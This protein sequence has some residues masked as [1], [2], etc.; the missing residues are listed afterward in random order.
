[1]HRP[2]PDGASDGAVLPA[3]TDVRRLSD[4]DLIGRFKLVC[5]LEQALLVPCAETGV[6]AAIAGAARH[7]SAEMLDI[8]DDLVRRI[9][10]RGQAVPR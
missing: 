8:V 2:T 9:V 3:G 4:A 6:H 10:Q 7:N 5:A 1:M